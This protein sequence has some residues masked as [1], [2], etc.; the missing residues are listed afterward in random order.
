MNKKIYKAICA[1]E[2]DE[3]NNPINIKMTFYCE[4]EEEAEKIVEFMSEALNLK[5]IWL[6][7]DYPILTFDLM[8]RTF[9]NDSFGG[10]FDGSIIN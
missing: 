3:Y 5:G 10:S 4:S 1:D 8:F 9:M 2:Y 7:E 6:V